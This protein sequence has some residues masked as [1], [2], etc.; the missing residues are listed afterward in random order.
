MENNE[1]EK[2]IDTISETEAD[3]ENLSSPEAD[4]GSVIADILHVLGF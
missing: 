4:S 2:K 1:T 3:S